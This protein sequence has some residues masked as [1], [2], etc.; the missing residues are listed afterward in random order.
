MPVLDKDFS[1]KFEEEKVAYLKDAKV[2]S[3]SDADAVL[4]VLVKGTT[5]TQALQQLQGKFSP[6]TTKRLQIADY[7]KVIQL[8][9]SKTVNDATDEATLWI[10]KT[11]Q[12]TGPCIDKLLERHFLAMSPQEKQKAGPEVRAQ[13]TDL[14]SNA[15]GIK[16]SA[17]RYSVG[18]YW[19]SDGVMGYTGSFQSTSTIFCRSCWSETFNTVNTSL[20]PLARTIIHEA[21]HRIHWTWGDSGLHPIDDSSPAAYQKAMAFPN[22]LSYPDAYA[23]FAMEAAAQC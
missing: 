16:S 23:M 13:L 22:A 18:G 12:K 5:L 15:Y 10:D 1:Q 17:V 6:L 20:K 21:L 7:V 4:A 8:D 14:K 9:A 2:L 3:E 19:C 11:L